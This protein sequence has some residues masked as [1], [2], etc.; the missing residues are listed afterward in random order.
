MLNSLTQE[1]LAGR[2][3]RLRFQGPLQSRHRLYRLRQVCPRGVMLRPPRKRQVEAESKRDLPISDVV[4][5]VKPNLMPLGSTQRK[6]KRVPASRSSSTRA[7]K[8]RL[9]ARPQSKLLRAEGSLRN[10]VG[11]Q[12]RPWEAP[13]AALAVRL[14]Q[15]VRRTRGTLLRQPRRIL[16]SNKDLSVKHLEVSMLRLINFRKEQCKHRQCFCSWEEEVRVTLICLKLSLQNFESLE[17]LI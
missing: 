8:A 7:M 10:P 9:L 2:G 15:A 5:R 13:R 6:R 14:R 4:V 3:Q 11:R 1:S 12:L 16:P 17:C